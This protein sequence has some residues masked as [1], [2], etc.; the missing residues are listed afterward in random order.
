[1]LVSFPFDIYII[2]HF[3]RF[4]NRFLKISV[5]LFLIYGYVIFDITK[6]FYNVDFDFQIQTLQLAFNAPAFIS[7]SKN[8]F[9]FFASAFAFSI[10][11]F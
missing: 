4:V 5:M 3:L 7:I 6:S 1:M 11:N 2:S 10:F 9:L 8:Q